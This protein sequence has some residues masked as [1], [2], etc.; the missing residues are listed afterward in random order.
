MNIQN[1]TQLV[2]VLDEHLFNRMMDLINGGCI[3]GPAKLAGFVL[4][5]CF[6]DAMAGFY[7]GID[8]DSYKSKSGER[9]KNFVAHFLTDKYNATN[10]YEDL[11]CGLVHAFVSGPKYVFVHDK[12]LL[13]KMHDKNNLVIINLEDFIADL[14]EA[15]RMFRQE[16]LTDKNIFNKC[17]IRYNSLGLMSEMPITLPLNII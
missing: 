17:L 3:K 5:A 2:A 8:K 16:V 14:I 15:Y 12:P 13:H 1:Q 6:I 7:F 4:G 11:R 9:F 10:L